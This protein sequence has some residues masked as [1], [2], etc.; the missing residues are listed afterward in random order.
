MTPI[1]PPCVESFGGFQQNGSDEGIA[2]SVRTSTSIR[3][4]QARKSTTKDL[5]RC[6]IDREAIQK[7][8]SYQRHQNWQ[9]RWQTLHRVLPTRLGPGPVDM[10]QSLW[11]S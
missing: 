1:V 6:G 3:P 2:I 11:C 4:T 9:R 10:L 8:A 5:K 7:A